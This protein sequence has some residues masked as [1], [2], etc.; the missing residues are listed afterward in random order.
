MAWPKGKKRSKGMPVKCEV[1]GKSFSIYGLGGHQR[2][3][4]S[5]K[6][7]PVA[8]QKV[9]VPVQQM[10]AKVPVDVVSRLLAQAKDHRQK[11]KSAEF[12]AKQ[13]RKLRQKTEALLTVARLEL[14][15]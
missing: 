7:Q 5:A 10:T 4:K 13:M 11:A 6:P 9:A 14:N 15:A 2:L 12:L 3:H 1:C 8:S